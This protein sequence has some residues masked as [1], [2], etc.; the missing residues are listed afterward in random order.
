MLHSSRSPSA[1]NRDLNASEE[2][3]ANSIAILSIECFG[4]NAIVRQVKTAVRKNAIN[5]ERDEA[6]V[7]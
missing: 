4:L 6:D 1:D 2:Y 5:V 3:L 7:G